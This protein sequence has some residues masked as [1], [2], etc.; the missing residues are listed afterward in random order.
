MPDSLSLAQTLVSLS[1]H[2]DADAQIEHFF[3]Y[4]EKNNL[5]GML[6][7]IKNHVQRIQQRNDDFNTLVI[8]SRHPLNEGD[9]QTIK[10]ITGADSTTLVHTQINED[11]LGSFQAQYQG[12]MHDGS[13]HG[14]VAQLNNSLT[15]SL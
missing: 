8:H 7:G 2:D 12:K 13:L 15:V 6:P 10:N 9:I 1:S 14:A 4:L 3:S 11:V 5:N